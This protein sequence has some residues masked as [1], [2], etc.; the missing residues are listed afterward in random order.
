VR[1]EGD[2]PPGKMLDGIRMTTP[3]EIYRYV[4]GVRTILKHVTVSTLEYNMKML[5]SY[6][7]YEHPKTHQIFATKLGKRV[8]LQDVIKGSKGPWIHVTGDPNDYVH[9]VKSDAP[10]RTVKRRVATSGTVGVCYV[11]RRN[12]WKA[13]LSGKL[14]GY[15]KTEEEASKSRLKALMALSPMMKFVPEGTDPD[16]RTGMRA[17]PCDTIEGGRPDV[18]VDQD[19]A[20]SLPNLDPVSYGSEPIKDLDYWKAIP[21]PDTIRTLCD[22]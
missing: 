14:I 11:E 20:E 18:Y 12:R 6:I 19:D 15:Y 3:L 9:L 10:V 13:T 2:G 4:D 5:C 16:G 8:Y 22:I 1:R 7:W 21:P 17:R